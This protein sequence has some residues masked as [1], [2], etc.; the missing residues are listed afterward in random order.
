MVQR[1]LTDDRFL[2]IL[3]HLSAITSLEKVEIHQYAEAQLG[4]SELG[5]SQ[6]CFD[7]HSQHTE[8]AS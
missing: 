4:G 1:D 7:R 8:L 6:F 5:F 3:V 2:G